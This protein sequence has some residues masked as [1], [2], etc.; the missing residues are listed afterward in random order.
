[1][2]K[3]CSLVSSYKFVDDKTISYSYSGD[4]TK[5]LQ[6]ALDIEAKETQKDKMLINVKK[7]HA[8][9]FNNSQKNTEPQNLILD[10]NIIQSCEKI[11]LLGVII[12]NDLKWSDNTE[13]ICAKVSRKFYILGR[14]KKFG[15]KT[16]ELVFAWKTIIRPLTEYATPLWHSGLTEGDANMIE[17]LQKKALGIILKLVFI[18]FRKYYKLNKEIL[19]YEEALEKLGLET[20]CYRREV[21]TCKFALSLVKSEK[22]REMIQPKVKM[23]NT[24]SNAMFN[25]LNCNSKRSYMSAV[26]YMTRLLNGVK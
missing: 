5:V 22:H 12:S 3:K 18:D 8:I 26:S 14:L 10:G 16:E 25:E 7:C 21:L 19:K 6:A 1:M 17:D 2:V 15:F 13:N 11:K 9:T 23:Y 4:P 24:Q 20:L